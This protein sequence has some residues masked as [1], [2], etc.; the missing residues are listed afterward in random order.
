MASGKGRC[1]DDLFD[2]DDMF[3]DDGQNAKRQKGGDEWRSTLIKDVLHT[4]FS[5]EQLSDDVKRHVKTES[6]I[7]AS[8]VSRS[9][10]LIERATKLDEQVTALKGGNVPAGVKQWRCN[11]DVPELDLPVPSELSYFEFKI[12]EQS[13]FRQLVEGSCGG[14]PR[15]AS[16]GA[17]QY[18][19]HRALPHIIA[20]L[21]SDRGQCDL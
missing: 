16:M 8:K 9:L 20:R 15:D 14:R 21:R 4:A 13:T 5:A 19:F 3:S 18:W 6:E 2:S 11:V 17:P 7:R 10:N 12:S 1:A